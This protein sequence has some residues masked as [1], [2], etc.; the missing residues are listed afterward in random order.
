ME[1]RIASYTETKVGFNNNNNN[2]R[3]LCMVKHFRPHILN[4]NYI[5]LLQHT[6]I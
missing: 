1:I 4:D 5:I 2:M 3:T 6:T